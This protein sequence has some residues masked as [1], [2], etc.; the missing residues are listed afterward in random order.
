MEILYG[1]AYDRVVCPRR[2]ESKFFLETP[3][4]WSCLYRRTFLQECE[5]RFNETPG[6]SYQDTSFVFLTKA[7]A[8]RFLFVK[9]GYL[10]YRIDNENSSTH[11]TKKIFSV[12]DEYDAVQ[13]HLDLHPLKE[14]RKLCGLSAQ[15]LYQN[16]RFTEERIPM[17]MYT[18]FWAKGYPKL[19]AAQQNGV[20]HEDLGDSIEAWM[21]Q[22]YMSY[23]NREILREGFLPLWRSAPGAYLF[24]AG[25]VAKA[26]VYNF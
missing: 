5:I 24:G 4:I 15:L 25:Q 8:E 17:W 14:Y 16:F 1:H 11:S 2:E 21:L 6:A 12:I 9:E 13:R 22:R 19:K 10:H 7:Y 20:F 23:R 3:S 26:A 18:T